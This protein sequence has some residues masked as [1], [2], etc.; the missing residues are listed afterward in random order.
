MDNKKIQ[1]KVEEAMHSIDHIERVSPPPFF[2]TRLH[3]RMLR[4]SNA[5]V[6][7]SSFFA[8]PAIAFACI[9]VVVLLNLFVVLKEEQSYSSDNISQ[10]LDVNSADEYSVVATSSY[11]LDK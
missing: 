11:D 7:V 1:E 9:C 6:K 10:T 5:W 8:R 2:F 3:A 4:E